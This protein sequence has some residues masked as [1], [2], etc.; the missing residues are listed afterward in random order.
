M[1]LA[2]TFALGIFVLAGAAIAGLSKNGDNIRE[3]SIAVALGA[4]V[5]LLATDLIPEAVEEVDTIGIPLALVFVAIG[6]VGLVALDHLL[7]EAQESHDHTHSHDEHH[8][9]H[10]HSHS[11]REH[12]HLHSHA[13]HIS[14]ITTIALVIHNVI[15]GMSVY[16]VSL[17]DAS[18]AILL[19]FGVGMHNLPMGM[20]VYSGVRSE[21]PRRKIIVLGCAALSTFLGGIIMFMLGAAITEPVTLALICLTIGMILYIVLMELIPHALH[22]S[23]KKLTLVSILAGAAIVFA[24]GLFKTLV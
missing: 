18:T 6:F 5:M 9:D 7:P 19:A 1:G 11:D 4:L 15:E 22:A 8:H 23:K 12:A 3:I 10:G 13:L 14:I 17:G 21:S 20:I 16:G 2:I 24:S